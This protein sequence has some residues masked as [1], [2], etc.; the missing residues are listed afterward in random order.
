MGR[1][2]KERVTALAEP[3]LQELG[4][5]LVD[6]QYRKE[7]ANWYLRLFIDKEGGVN[8]E[9]CR[10]ASEILSTRL[11]EEDPIPHSYFLEVSSPG[12]ERSLKKEQDFIRFQGHTIK[13]KT[14]A[15]IGGQKN[16]RG[17]L[18]GLDKGYVIIE[19]E[20]GPV[21]IPWEQIA[22]ANLVAEF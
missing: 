13:V 4:L 1:R 7:G 10:R 3:I 21:A 22:H 15:P 19:G 17:I 12:I 9:D 11:D 16:F 6:V 20:K 5:E 2:V 18:R 8:L 14:F